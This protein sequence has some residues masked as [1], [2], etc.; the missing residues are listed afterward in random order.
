MLRTAPITQCARIMTICPMISSTFSTNE[1][2]VSNYILEPLPKKTS[3]INPWTWLKNYIKHTISATKL[4][5]HDGKKY[6]RESDS[7]HRT[8]MEYIKRKTTKNDLLKLVPFSVFIVV[9]FAE[10]LL[11]VYLVFYQNAIP[12]RFLTK[13]G[14]RKNNCIISLDMLRS[15]QD[16]RT[17]L[18]NYLN[19]LGNFSDSDMEALNIVK[20]WLKSNFDF[21]NNIEDLKKVNEI[22]EKLIFPII[23]NEPDFLREFM[24]SIGIRPMT[25]LYYMN[26]LLKLASFDPI[27]LRSPI[28]RSLF[29]FYPKMRVRSSFVKS[30]DLDELIT[31]DNLY[32][33]SSETIIQ[34]AISKGIVPLMRTEE[35]VKRRVLQCVD[36][37]KQN[38]SV[39]TIILANICANK[40]P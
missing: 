28:I 17:N 35:D 36:L 8:L 34:I 6:F 4:S 37:R 29:K 21:E 15:Q 39:P 27:T 26:S 14:Q 1:N 31:K 11:P 7:E 40:I 19:K 13:R 10:L 23:Y 30:N 16:L 32:E 25:G 18:H 22:V 12:S 2:Q 38:I 3:R 9:P 20:S 24:F 5:Y 33:L